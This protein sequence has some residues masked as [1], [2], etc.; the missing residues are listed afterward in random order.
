MASH[1]DLGTIRKLSQYRPFE[2][3]GRDAREAQEDL[4]LAALAEAGGTLES[5]RACC[6]TIAVLFS[7]HLDE[8]EVGA[9]LNGLVKG[10]RVQRENG[11]FKL[12]PVEQGRLEAAARESL[13][14]ATT[15]L[16][17]WIS[18]IKDNFPGLSEEEEECLREDLGVYLRTVVQRHGAEAALVLYPSEPEA[19]ALHDDLE[20]LGFDFLERR[21]SRLHGVR[22][23]ALSQFMRHPT[24][25]QR[26]F[27]G[28]IL[29]TGYFWT[30]LSIDPD[31][32]NLVQEITAGQRVYLDTNFLFRLLGIQ[33][34]RFIRPGEILL[35]RTQEAGYETVVTPWTLDELRGALRASRDFLRSHPIPPSEYAALAAEVTSDEDF[36][37]L[38][39]RRVR[40]EPGLSVDDFL[41]Y[42]EEIEVHLEAKGIGVSGEGCKAVEQR[43]S[44]IVDQVA[45][46]E[47]ATRYGKQRPLPSLEH[48]V[49]HRLLIEKRRGDANRTFA[50]AGAWFLTHDSILPRYDNLAR[51]ESGSALPFCV[52]A[53]AWFQVVEAFSPKSGDLGQTLADLLASPYVRYRRSLTKASA[54]AIVART[55][56][57]ADG[58]P[59]LAARVF[60]NSSSVDEIEK[61]ATSDEKA[62]KI[63]NAVIT[64]A[65]EVQ[66][67]A[68]RAKEQAE[69]ARDQA[70]AAEAAATER[71]RT[72]ERDREDAIERE[73]SLR[74]DAVA[75]EAARGRMER[76]AETARLQDKLTSAEQAT[77]RQE[78]LSRRSQRRLRYVGLGIASM[79]VFV[80]ISLI[81]GV[82]TAWSYVVGAGIVLGIAA[83]VDQLAGR[84]DPVP[85]VSS[86]GEREEAE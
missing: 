68:R 31:G 46:M 30:V 65:R 52:S 13:D 41:A 67:E 77:K 37:T 9:A 47:G 5:V 60:M 61:A 21:N 57:H 12:S 32:A 4:L 55:S 50:T 42:F 44:D 15:A 8:V 3:G 39:W 58:S 53:G 35:Q 84:R 27:I 2:R 72:A 51:R 48:D 20:T 40:N 45:L 24:D 56:L 71:I 73:R 76:D 33:G 82:T 14:I 54:Q 22:Q 63:D 69:E 78:A 62:E 80:L 81:A 34:P 70:R 43:E 83:G 18:S 11:E 25:V 17:E 64:A 29:S 79:L 49:S 23:W 26:A 7:L 85:A 66:D 19:Q 36:V 38:Y 10:K 75:S 74:D 59:E 1:A 6:E 28:Q 16:D 86:S